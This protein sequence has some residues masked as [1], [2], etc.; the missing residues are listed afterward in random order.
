MRVLVADDDPSV[1]ALVAIGLHPAEV[2]EAGDGHE[3][4]QVLESTLVDVVLLDVMMPG[5]D[6]FAVLARIRESWPNGGPAV[7]MLTGLTEELDHVAAFRLGADGYITKPVDP[8]ELTDEAK[9]AHLRSPGERRR[10][11]EAELARAEFLR[12]LETGFNDSVG[13]AGR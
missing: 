5:H 3:A 2:I 4:L 1:R 9:R 13:R 8:D 7:L 10:H 6:G 11:R 12:T